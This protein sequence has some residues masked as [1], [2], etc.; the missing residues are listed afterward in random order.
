MYAV[1]HFPPANDGGP[2]L[3]DHFGGFG[4]ALGALFALQATGTSPNSSMLMPGIL[5]LAML[6]MLALSIIAVRK[7]A[8]TPRSARI[9]TIV[10]AFIS[11]LLATFMFAQISTYAMFF[12]A[13]IRASGQ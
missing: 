11:M 13:G 7:R 2:R 5:L 6:D 8:R 4:F 3:P 10:L 1:F 9:V 12:Q